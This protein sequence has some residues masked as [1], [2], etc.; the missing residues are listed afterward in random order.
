M[1]INRKYDDLNLKLEE[2]NRKRLDLVPEALKHD[3]NVL[4]YH[5]FCWKYVD[6]D[7]ITLGVS[8][9]TLDDGAEIVPYVGFAHT[10]THNKWKATQEQCAKMLELCQQ[11]VAEPT[12]NKS[13]EIF[14]Y[15]QECKPWAGA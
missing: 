2:I 7:K 4:P 10:Y 15:L 9:Y 1:K 6:F 3:N 14:D 11:L 12:I 8:P 13:T 5:S